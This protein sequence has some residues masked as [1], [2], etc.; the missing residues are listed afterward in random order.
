MGHGRVME[1]DVHDA[2]TRLEQSLADERRERQA[3]EAKVERM[4][5][6]GLD[7]LDF[8]NLFAKS[9]DG[10]NGTSRQAARQNHTHPGD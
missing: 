5:L 10:D 6:H 4:R 7:T 2:M 1:H 8:Q 9:G 3:L